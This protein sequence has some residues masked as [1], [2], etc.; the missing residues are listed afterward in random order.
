[1]SRKYFVVADW[2]GFLR[3]LILL[4]HE[5]HRNWK[6]SLLSDVGLDLIGQFDVL[7]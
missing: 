4:W 1:L 2:G 5:F 6:K 7:L 3:F